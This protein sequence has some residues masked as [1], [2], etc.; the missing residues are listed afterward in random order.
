M[1]ADKVS[2]GETA[3]QREGT[4]VYNYTRRVSYGIVISASPHDNRLVLGSLTFSH[5]I[6]SEVR[7]GYIGPIFVFCLF[8]CLIE[9]GRDVGVTKGY[10]TSPSV[11]RKRFRDISKLSFRCSEKYFS[12]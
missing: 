8:F 4:R 11:T 3:Q 2:K 6:E 12:F 5:T 7:F 9:K 1:Y 10:L